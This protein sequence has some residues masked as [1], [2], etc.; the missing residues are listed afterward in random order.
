MPSGVTTNIQL[1]QLARH[2]HVL[3]FRSVFMRN[4]LPINGARRNKS[5][6]VNLDDT[7]GPG[8]H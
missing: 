5:G 3:Y 4:A 2:M 7:R 6:V 1:D 8:T